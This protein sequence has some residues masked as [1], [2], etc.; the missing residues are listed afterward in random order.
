VVSLLTCDEQ[1]ERVFCAAGPSG[2]R[3]GHGHHGRACRCRGADCA[4]RVPAAAV[5]AVAVAYVSY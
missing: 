4:I 1:E 3:T 5:V 2:T